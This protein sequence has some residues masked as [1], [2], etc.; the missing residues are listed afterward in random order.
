MEKSK[1]TL[2]HLSLS[3]P[4][5]ET[6]AAAAGA[7]FSAVGLRIC[8]RR[9]GESYPGAI[10]GDARA[11]RDLRRQIDDAGIRL[12]NVS[13]YQF[14]PEVG[15]EDLLPVV[16]TVVLLETPIVV[17]NSY[18]TDDTRFTDTFARYCAELA[19]HGIRIALEF[20]PYSCVR[21]L[22]QAMRIIELSGAS[23]AG[24]LLDALHLDR[25]GATAADVARL[26]PER[27]IFAQLCDAR[28]L[29][30]PLSDEALQQEARTGRLPAGEGDLPLFDFLDALPS[31]TEIEYEVTRADMLQSS[32]LDK[33]RA[34]RIDADRFMSRFLAARPAWRNRLV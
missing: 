19:P 2:A 32:A 33:A 27:V 17:V 25:S 9:P 7:G 4:P 21:N 12:S 18:D 10:V 20:L 5:A 13:A 15:W 24:V 3:A 30:A 6:I 28:K 34:A 8:A 31:G 14:F 16:D 11:T 23:N 29:T 22:V 26:A 1:L